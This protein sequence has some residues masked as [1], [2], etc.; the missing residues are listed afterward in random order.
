MKNK[1]I[2][3]L[4]VIGIILFAALAFIRQNP[5]PAAP[6]KPCC[7]GKC[8]GKPQDNVE[9]ILRNPVNRLIVATWK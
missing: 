3:Q 5:K 6:E 2:L 4:F 7:Q 8:N 1:P 9:S